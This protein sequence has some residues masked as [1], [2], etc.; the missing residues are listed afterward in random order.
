M[1]VNPRLYL[2]S[3]DDIKPFTENDICSVSG[4]EFLLKCENQ[5]FKKLN[6]GDAIQIDT[7]YRNHSK[8]FW[9][10]G[11]YSMDTE[12]F[13]DYGTLDER[14][15]IFSKNLPLDYFNDTMYYNND[16]F[17]WNPKLYLSQ[18]ITN[19]KFDNKINNF[20]TY[21]MWRNKKIKLTSELHNLDKSCLDGLEK[22]GGGSF[23]KNNKY[24]I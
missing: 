13:S 20:K 18:I 2:V 8:F 21:F 7:E 9:D 19:I 10:D 24:Y 12:T 6:W 15:S 23:N 3:S 4:R 17:P 16:I 5:L 14:F 11:W 22:N 1:S